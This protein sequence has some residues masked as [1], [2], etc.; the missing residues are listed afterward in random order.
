MRIRS[1]VSSALLMA[2][3]LLADLG[4][5]APRAN[6]ASGSALGVGVA[7]AQLDACLYQPSW[8]CTHGSHGHYDY[9]PDGWCGI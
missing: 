3:L 4:Q 9:C 8:H 2:V 1:I 6:G 5:A 7:C